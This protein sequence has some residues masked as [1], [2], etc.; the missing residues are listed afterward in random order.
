LRI[1]LR[2]SPKLDRVVFR[3]QFNQSSVL[4]ARFLEAPG[5]R[6]I[7]PVKSMWL[8]RTRCK[9][10]IALRSGRQWPPDQP[11]LDR[12]H[13]VGESRLLDGAAIDESVVTMSRLMSATSGLRQ[14]RAVPPQPIVGQMGT[15]PPTIDRIVAAEIFP[16]GQDSLPELGQ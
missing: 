10:R 8:R 16:T 15:S 9:E 2:P 14:N 6:I 13:E 7:Q 4:R 5:R 1:W 3:E 12:D 11:A